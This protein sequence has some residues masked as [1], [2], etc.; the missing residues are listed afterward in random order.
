MEIGFGVL[1]MLLMVSRMSNVL[2]NDLRDVSNYGGSLLRWYA[3]CNTLVPMTYTP[4]L[5]IGSEWT[6]VIFGHGKPMQGQHGKFF[7]VHVT[8]EG[9][10]KFFYCSPFVFESQV[11]GYRLDKLAPGTVIRLR[12]SDRVLAPIEVELSPVAQ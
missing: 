10:E 8:H 2:Q 9:V 12:K 5:I 4:K 6:K 1:V 7:K 11:C 3:A